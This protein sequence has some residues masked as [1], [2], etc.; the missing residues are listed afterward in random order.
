MKKLTVYI[1]ALFICSGIA[2]ALPQTAF[3]ATCTGDGGTLSSGTCTIILTSPTGSNQTFTSPSDWSNGAN[4]IEVIGAGASGGAYAK[5]STATASGGGGGAY[6]KISN[7]SFASPGVTTATYQIGTGGTAVAQSTAGGSSGHTGG[8]TWFN[9]SSFPGAGTDN[10]KVGAKGGTLGTAGTTA[11]T[12]GAG[13]VDTSGWGQ[14]RSV[15]GNGGSTTATA[16][17]GGGGGAAGSTGVGGNSASTGAGAGT[18]GKNGQ[19][20]TGGSGTTG[21]NTKT[22]STGCNGTEWTSAG[23]GCGGGGGRSTTN[24]S[25]GV[26]NGGAGGNYGGGGGA[27]VTSGGTS[28][29]TATSGAGIGGIIVIKYTVATAPSLTTSAA[30]TVTVI[31]ANING[32]ITATGGQNATAEGF[33]TSTDPAM[34]SGVSTS[35]FS[36][37]FGTGAFSK[38][39]SN[40]SLTGNTTYYFRAY[41]TNSAGDGLGSIL[42]F[43]TLPGTPGT[44]TYSSV[45]PTSMTVNW[46]APS[47]GAATYNL[48][49]CITSANTCTL[50]TGI[51]ATSQAVSSLSNNT[52]YDFAVQGVNATGNGAWSAT[53]TQSTNADLPSL[54]TDAASSITSSGG[55]LNSTISGV[56]GAN[57]TTCGFAYGTDSTL[58]SV[59]A[60]TTDST[61]PSGTGSFL[62]ILSGLSAAVTYY[63]RAYATNTGGTGYGSIANFTTGAAASSARKLHLFEGFK[64]KFF[65][66]TIK[67]YG[68]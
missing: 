18:G 67:F 28:A 13:G 27:A 56:G 20:T 38:T 45:A 62:K 2:G 61:C 43:L 60:T 40:T 26:A 48:E 49:R 64:I 68:N 59:I 25:S 19:G 14:T 39:F 65:N 5:A 52:S 54:S 9:S 50:V 37:S 34:A 29:G 31:S 35:T 1:L 11:Q 24:S 63:F 6:S 58:A 53:S 30:D 12:G 32:N 33:A 46:S 15:G 47:G 16:A 7:F 3:A 17:A 66:G 4:T 51:A 36:G 22:G 10:S 8:D 44:P 55:T 23:S 41:A 57:A 21:T 42:N